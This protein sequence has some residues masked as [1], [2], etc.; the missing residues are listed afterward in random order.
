MARMGLKAG[1]LGSPLSS[2]NN[3]RDKAIGGSELIR[4]SMGD[5][6]M[7]MTYEEEEEQCDD[8]AII[9]AA[10]QSASV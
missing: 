10:Q 3:L 6:T 9:A 2:V 8:C 5:M 4:H 7:P 1:L